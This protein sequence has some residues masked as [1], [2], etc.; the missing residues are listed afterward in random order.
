LPDFAKGFSLILIVCRISFWL[1]RVL[2]LPED[3]RRKG[4]WRGCTEGSSA[5]MH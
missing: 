5:S 2:I 3:V 4:L 1:F